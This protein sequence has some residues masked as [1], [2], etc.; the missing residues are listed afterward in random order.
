MLE[1]PRALV[2]PLPLSLACEAVYGLLW[3]TIVTVN[4]IYQA[5]VVGLTPLELVLVGSLLEG[6]CLVSEVPTGVV[7]DLRSRRLSVAVGI[8]LIGAGF[9]LEGSIAELW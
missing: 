5:V 2:A 8:V 3:S 9:A 1:R 4:L 6:V 7:A